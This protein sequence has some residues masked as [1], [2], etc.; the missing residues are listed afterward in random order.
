MISFADSPKDSGVTRLDRA[1]LM[2]IVGS[3]G[4]N[5]KN[6]ATLSTL[7]SKRTKFTLFL[8]QYWMIT[9]GLPSNRK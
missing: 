4:M 7:F 9:N 8:I 5:Q 1:F 2:T 6:L 3:A